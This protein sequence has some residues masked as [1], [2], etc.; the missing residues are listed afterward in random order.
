VLWINGGLGAPEQGDDR[1][2]CEIKDDAAIVVLVKVDCRRDVV[3]R[4][5]S[6]MFYP[7]RKGQRA[8][9][10]GVSPKLPAAPSTTS[11]QCPK[12]PIVNER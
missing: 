9:A 2:L 12:A 10:H 8:A 11:L 6:G 7:A 5:L 3:R 4:N 1:I